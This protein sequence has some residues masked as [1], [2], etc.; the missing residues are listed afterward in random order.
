MCCLNHCICGN[1]LPSRKFIQCIWLL[2]PHQCLSLLVSVLCMQWMWCKAK[3]CSLSLTPS[4]GAFF[5]KVAHFLQRADLWLTWG[6]VIL[7]FFFW[8]KT[9]FSGDITQKLQGATKPLFLKAS[10]RLL[11]II[12]KR[13]NLI[14]FPNLCHWPLRHLNCL[15]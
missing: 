14:S 4:W 15:S 5:R 11:E 10:Q 3:P 6:H 8:K 9:S 12:L 13:D 7:F 2:V 1:L